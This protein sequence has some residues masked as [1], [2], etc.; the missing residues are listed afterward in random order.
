MPR[1]SAPTLVE[2]RERQR[3][4]LLD[5]VEDLVLET[6]S[7]AITVSAVASKAGLARSSVYEYYGSPSA[8]LAATVVD[9]MQRWTLEVDADVARGRTPAERIELFVRASLDLAAKGAQRLGRVVRIADMPPECSDAL[10][11]MH[12]DMTRPLTMALEESRVDS[13]DR[14][15][16]FVIG[17][18]QAATLRIEAGSPRKSETEA[19]VEF[20]LRALALPC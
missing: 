14:A 6:G 3:A 8:L 9:R 5:A 7:T 20:V 10:A 11:E 19:A 12:R 2:H 15:A 1:I 4:A 13:P 16:D 17:I 18:V